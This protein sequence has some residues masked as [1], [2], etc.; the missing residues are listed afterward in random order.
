M[1]TSRDFPPLRNCLRILEALIENG[2]PTAIGAAEKAIDG[3]LKREPRLNRRTANLHALE[4]EIDR[5]WKGASSE[6]L[7][8]VN[9]VSEYISAKYRELRPEQ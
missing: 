6:R 8:F 2:D 3:F 7:V 4:Q 5:Q 9:L 1:Q